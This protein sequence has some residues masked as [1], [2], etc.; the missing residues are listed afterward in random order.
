MSRETSNETQAFY[1]AKY[2]AGK[3]IPRT[4]KVYTLE[5]IPAA[6]PAL[7]ILDVGCATGDNS[8]II[9]DSGHRVT[10]VD[11]SANA[12][13]KYKAA[14]FE[15]RVMD[16]SAGL[17][18]PD[19]SFDMV[20]CS[21]VIEHLIHPEDLIGEMAR[22][23]RPGGRVLLSTPNSAFWAYRVLALLGFT[24]SEVQH[25]MHL[26][27]FS[28]R[29]LTRAITDAGLKV[30]TM[31]GRNMY[32][33]IP[34]LRAAGPAMRKL[35]FV[36]EGRFRTGGSFWHLSYKSAILNG[37]FADTLIAMAVKPGKPAP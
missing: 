22:V 30:E 4:S 1:E 28:K 19:A 15:G 9:K 5:Q 12:I 27:F 14:G 3:E 21:E 13:E 2:A 32:L 31:I 36:E 20:F 23:L 6:P 18:F 26:R 29:S 11:I 37:L 25:P 35:G 24:L 10:G 7:D 16:I 33:L 34:G 17:D 8:R